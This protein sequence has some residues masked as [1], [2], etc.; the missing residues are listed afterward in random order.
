M[1]GE[2][3]EEACWI[4]GAEEMKAGETLGEVEETSWEA[5]VTLG[6][7]VLGWILGVRGAEETL[8]EE[9]EIVET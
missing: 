6:E 2:V 4:W 7:E 5:G 9:E 3:E 1:I 8:M